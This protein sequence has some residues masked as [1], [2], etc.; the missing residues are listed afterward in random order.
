M[1]E[2]SCWKP[3]TE[4]Q[5]EH[6]L[7]SLFSDSLSLP[8]YADLGHSWTGTFPQRHSCLLP[9]CPRWDS[10]SHKHTS[11]I[12]ETAEELL[13][14]ISLSCSSEK[15]KATLPII[16]YFRLWTHYSAVLGLCL[17]PAISWKCA[18]THLCPHE[19]AGCQVHCIAA[20]IAFVH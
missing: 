14:S 20:F 7:L 19:H 3:N 2:K 10:H 1:T 5:T 15:L 8:L 9:W 13:R 18:C 11:C 4:L 16:I 6:K 17:V 12:S